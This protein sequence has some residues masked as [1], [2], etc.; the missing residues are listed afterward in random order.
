MTELF[1]KGMKASELVE[2]ANRNA[3]VLLPVAST[4]QHGPHPAT[5]TDDVLCT[6][7]CRRAA[8]NCPRDLTHRGRTN[9]LDGTR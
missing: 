9:R 2:L 1:W 7:A 3:I 5:G 8:E 6:E 4:E